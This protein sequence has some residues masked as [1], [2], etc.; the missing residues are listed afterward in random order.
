VKI[1][2]RFP[3]F[4]LMNFF[5]M[6]ENNEMIQESFVDTSRPS[7]GRIYDYLLGG[8]H[9]FDVDRQAADKVVKL[10][11][12][13]PKAM[14][15]QRWCLQD[16]AWHLTRERGLDVLIDFGSGLPTMEHLHSSA[17][18]G[19]TIIYS[20][21]DPIVVEYA[22]EILKAVPSAYF[23]LADARHPEELLD[24]PDVKEILDGRTNV[25]AISWG[26]GGFL[27]DEDIRNMA[28]VLYTKTGP[29]SVWAF[30]AQGANSNVSD[31]DMMK[32]LET[33]KQ[34]GAPFHIRT[35]EEYMEL[36]KPWHPEGG[37]F[38]PLTEWNGFDQSLMTKNDLKSAGSGG[39]GYGA[40][41]IK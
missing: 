15:L 31:P 40:Y 12:F 38:I 25:G 36:I 2:K 37:R 8:S 4:L 5:F 9:N 23:F 30:N 14:R 34:M 16:L 27:A 39:G 33:Y 29:N 11:P 3:F 22:K 35:T 21:F 18:A 19:T 6:K 20:D 32:L 10:F 7:A 17:M 41:L 26:I 28:H 1:C 13:L 24:R